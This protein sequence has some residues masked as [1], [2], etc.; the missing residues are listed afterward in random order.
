MTAN[1]WL[2]SSVKASRSGLPAV[3]PLSLSPLRDSPSFLVR[4]AQLGA[5]DEFHRHFAGLGVTPARF[6]VFALIATNPDVRPGALSEE[7]RVKLRI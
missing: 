5:F 6:A 4:L 7:L 3:A 1:R 2:E